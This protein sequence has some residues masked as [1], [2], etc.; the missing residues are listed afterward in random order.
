MALESHDKFPE[1]DRS[2]ITMRKRHRNAK[3]FLDSRL[4]GNDE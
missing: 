4:R 2:D 3:A 1:Q